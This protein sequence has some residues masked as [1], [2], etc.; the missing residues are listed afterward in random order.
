LKLLYVQPAAHLVD[1][2]LPEVRVRQ[3]VLSF[4]YRIRFLLAFDP[5]LC[6]AVRGIFVRTILGWLRE[7]AEAEGAPGGSSGVVVLAQRFG[8]ALNLNLHF[9]ALVLDGVYTSR[10]LL[11]APRFH[12]TP[13]LRDEDVTHVTAILHLRIVRYLQRRGR[14]PREEHA[15]HDEPA[16]DEPLL[17]LISAAS[18]E[19]RVALGPTSGQPLTRRGRQRDR[20]PLFLPGELCCDLEGFSLHAKVAIEGHDRA[21]LERLCRYIARPAIA[22]ERLSIA[23]DGRVVYRLRRAWRDGTSA[24]VFEQLAFLERLA[25]LVPRARAHLLTYHGVLAP[26]AQWRDRIVP[27]PR[28]PTESHHG[29]TETR[30]ACSSR[31][32]TSSSPDSP[33][34]LSSPAR[35]RRLRWAELL[36][37]VFAV[38][39]LT[40]PHCGGTRRLIAMITEGLVVRRILDHL[41]LPS[42][43]PPIAPARAPP[44]PEFAW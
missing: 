24:I 36:R 9:H 11:A 31:P 15:G 25:A 6:S 2:V 27:G 39:V 1:L 8:G 40:C 42:S 33:A 19:G 35:T 5:A 16:P 14:L 29:S 22:S 13:E 41:E 17:A 26:A 23:S 32:A 12:P 37:R 43:P 44:E 34:A 20:R 21:G 18:V 30:A 4:P 3:W 38:D 28:R 10:G 7:R